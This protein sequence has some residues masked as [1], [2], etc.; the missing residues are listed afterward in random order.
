MASGGDA[1]LEAGGVQPA[2]EAPAG[3][4]VDLV[5]EQELEKLQRTELGLAGM[6]RAFGQRGSRPPRRRR[7][8]RR[9]RSA[10]S[11][12]PLLLGGA[13]WWAKL[14]GRAGEP[15]RE[16]DDGAAR[17]RGRL[18]LERGPDD[19]LDAAD[20]DQLEGQGA[21]AGGVDAGRDVALGQPQELLRL[22][23]A[24]PREGPAEQDGHEPADGS[25]DLGRA[26]DARSGARMA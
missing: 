16:R 21:R 18:V 13:G 14:R 26:T 22:A 6:G 19:R 8:R 3:A 25:P 12:R 20:L 24:G 23:E 15:G 5:R 2:L 9:T 10:G 1:L 4:P 17:A 11:P 7:L